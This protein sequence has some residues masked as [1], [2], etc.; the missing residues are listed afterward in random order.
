MKVSVTEI[1]SFRRC[2]RQW[3]YSYQQRLVKIVPSNPL[4]LGS[5]IHESHEIWLNN[6]DYNLAEIFIQCANHK[7]D[8]IRVLFKSNTGVDSTN[9]DLSAVLDQIELGLCMSKNYQLRWKT[10]LPE[11]LNLFA[12]E[13]EIEVNIPGTDHVLKARLD[14]LLQDN[15]GRI[16]ILEHKTYSVTPSQDSLDTNYQF[17]AYLWVASKL[18]L[19]EVAGIAYDGLY[20]RK[21]PVKGKTLDSLF[22]RTVLNRNYHELQEFETNL[23]L[24]A[25]DMANNPSI[26]PNRRWEGCYH[27]CGYEKLCRH[28]S[29]GEDSAYHR[30]QFYVDTAK[31]NQQE[32]N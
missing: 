18:N 12:P 16:F 31:L 30:D 27:D 17:L 32:E 5:L 22:M 19:G 21:E 4:V 7:L 14:A 20:K 10:P 6:P 15:K 8:E 25:N 24:E 9:D 29:R 23:A 13:Q 11:T 3:S 28:E 2:R 26:Y 1:Q